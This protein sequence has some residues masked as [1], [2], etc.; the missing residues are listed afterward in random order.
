MLKIPNPS[1]SHPQVHFVLRLE[2]ES[3]L[4][5]AFNLRQ[6]VDA[7]T[8]ALHSLA[9]L[10]RR[11]D[12]FVRWDDIVLGA[13]IGSASAEVGSSAETSEAAEAQASDSTGDVNMDGGRGNQKATTT[14]NVSRV[15]V[16]E[17]AMSLRRKLALVVGQ[18]RVR[19][20]LLAH[21]A[22][23]FS[24]SSSSSSSSSFSP[25]L[26]S[27][28]AKTRVN[29]STS[30]SYAGKQHAAAARAQADAAIVA[31]TRHPLLVPEWPADDAALGGGLVAP[32]IVSAQ[33]R[34]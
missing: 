9:L 24:S 25:A 20:Y 8:A 29:H 32:E 28:L 2:R 27:S 19:S 12:R 30:T 13:A 21:P 11:A 22:V 34:L 17:D 5:R 31:S 10:P 4:S 15:V 26:S 14:T 16:I 23:S 3:D 33:V 1:Y 7:L 18:L 6:M